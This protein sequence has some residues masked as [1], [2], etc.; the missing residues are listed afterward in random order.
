MWHNVFIF[1]RHLLDDARD[2]ALRQA[3]MSLLYRIGHVPLPLTHEAIWPNGDPE[4]FLR[5]LEI[6]AEGSESPVASRL[7]DSLTQLRDSASEHPLWVTATELWPK[8]PK[9]ACFVCSRTSMVPKLE[10]RAARHQHPA[11]VLAASDHEDMLYRSSALVFGPPRSFPGWMKV[12]QRLPTYWVHFAWHRPPEDPGPFLPFSKRGGTVLDV[13]SMGKRSPAGLTPDTAWE[14]P[15]ELDPVDWKTFTGK[16]RAA[17]TTPDDPVDDEVVPAVAG[18]LT[19]EKVVLLPLEARSTVF[20]PETHEVRGLLGSRLHA[21]LFVI[22]REGKGR[23]HIRELVES[24]FLKD[25]AS[26]RD[27]LTIWKRALRQAIRGRGLEKVTE[28]LRRRGVKAVDATVKSWA[29]EMVYGPGNSTW[30]LAVMEL[31]EIA[32]PELHWDCVE[33]YRAAGRQAGQFVRA[34]LLRQ[35]ENMDISTARREST[36]RFSLEG[37]EG[38]ALTAHKLE[39]V[40]QGP[41][42]VSPDLIGNVLE[43]GDNSWHG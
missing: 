3:T 35:I 8:L 43:L 11:I 14:S 22:V 7:H 37:I 40:E 20:D 28:E 17:T 39:A 31:L 42:D 26:A 18:V 1:G 41:F 4:S 27:R 38:G 30:F 6:F 23:D 15:A 10:E 36:L 5:M 2:P 25:A 33:A 21:G 19:D 16:L 24:R 9:P 34:S 13:R 29:T 32:E 12:M